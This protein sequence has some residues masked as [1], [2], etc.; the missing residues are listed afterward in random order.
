MGGHFVE[1]HQN[2]IPF[3]EMLT[4]LSL[5]KTGVRTSPVRYIQSQNGNLSGEFERLRVD[6]S[7]LE[8]VN[9][10]IGGDISKRFTNV[11]LG[12][13]PDASN[14]WIGNEESTTSLHLGTSLVNDRLCR[15]L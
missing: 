15:S 4:W 1:P 7:E 9:E 12:A 5:R 2:T 11:N 8:W 13:P 14:I 6:V 10:C 3:T